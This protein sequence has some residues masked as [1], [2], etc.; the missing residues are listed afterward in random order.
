MIKSDFNKIIKGEPFDLEAKKDFIKSSKQSLNKLK[1][2]Y[3]ETG[4]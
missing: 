3:S 4:L 2:Y 1:S